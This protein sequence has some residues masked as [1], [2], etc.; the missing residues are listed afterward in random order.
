MG[1]VPTYTVVFLFPDGPSTVQVRGDEFILA[2]ARRQG[3]QLPSLCEIGW[4]IT[5]AVA[6]LEGEIDQSASRRFYSADREAGFA[7]I[8][9]GRP[10]SNLRLRPY[11]TEQMRAHRLAKRL[12]VPRGTGR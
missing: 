7:L 3:L 5:C 6:V 8:C 2:A 4:C 9:T 12:P 10:R 11:A 1:E